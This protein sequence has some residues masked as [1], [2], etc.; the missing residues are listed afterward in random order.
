MSGTGFFHASWDELPVGTVLEG[1]RQIDAPIERLFESVRRS[2]A[3]NHAQA[4]FMVRDTRELDKLGGGIGN[5]VYEVAPTGAVTGPL[6]G[7]WY[8]EIARTHMTQ[9]RWQQDL[10]KS[11]ALVRAAMQ[12]WDG[13]KCPGGNAYA[14]SWEYLAEGARVVRRVR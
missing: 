10:T 7:R 12:Y 8:G 13:K 4:V 3:P 1:R 11:A 9:Y 6:D 5:I 2:S 14:G